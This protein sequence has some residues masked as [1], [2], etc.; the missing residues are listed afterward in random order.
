[1]LT[2]YPSH[3]FKQL[4][5]ALVGHSG[6]TV[7]Q[8]MET[9]QLTLHLP[10]T[11]PPSPNPSSKH[12]SLFSTSTNGNQT[13]SASSVDGTDDIG[14]TQTKA[15]TDHHNQPQT[16][17]S[18]NIMHGSFSSLEGANK[19]AVVHYPSASL[20]LSGINTPSEESTTANNEKEIRIV[21]EEEGFF[22]VDGHSPIYSGSVTSQLRKVLDSID[23]DACEVNGENAFFIA[24]LSEVYRQH[25][26]WI[27]ALPRV[28]PYYAVKCNPDPYVLRLLS[29]LGCGFDCASNGEIQNVLDLGVSPERIIY[30]NPC[31]AASFVRQARLQ[32]VALTTFDNTDELAKMK[33]FHPECKLV[34][35]ILTDDSKSVCQ[36]GLK[37]GAPLDSVPRL[38][39]KARQLDLD[40]VGVSFHVGSGCYDAGA[41]ADAISRARRAF[42]MGAEAGYEFHLLDVGGGYAHDNFDQ[43]ATV[44][45][46]AI[47]EQFSDAEFGPSNTSRR[48]PLSIIAEPGRYYVQRAFVLATNIIARR[49]GRRSSE[50]DEYDDEE[51]EDE[52]VPQEE[53]SG[54]E[55]TK[56]DGA[57]EQEKPKVMY[58]QNDGVYASFNCLLFDHAVVH[59]RVLTLQRQFVYDETLPAPGVPEKSPL[60]IPPDSVASASASGSDETETETDPLKLQPCSVWGPTCDS[61]DCVKELAYLPQGLEVGDWLVYDNMGGYTLCAASSFNGLRPSEVRYT[62]GGEEEE[63]DGAREVRALLS[64]SG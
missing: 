5:L 64:G 36:L 55:P 61:I 58:Y 15:L 12:E 26:R 27:K 56:E 54:A 38:L 10:P 44:L 34:V 43:I 35:R 18:F 28:V 48:R 32:R 7:S 25:Q 59:P 63:E 46:G 51:E 20:G 50:D 3:A 42:E 6:T 24:N 21:D 33:R 23:V 13:E 2:L 45:R 49:D 53:G 17:A 14:I 4:S 62:F 37:F 60:P 47:D 52:V 31:K 40:V 22:P 57:N 19:T 9:S 1:M 16:T 30:A 29:A 41:F 11:A 8:L 39:A